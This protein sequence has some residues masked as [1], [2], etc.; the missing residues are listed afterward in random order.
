MT[1]SAWIT[2]LWLRPHLVHE[3]STFLPHIEFHMTSSWASRRF[4][5]YHRVATLGDGWY[6]AIDCWQNEPCGDLWS[7]RWPKMM[8]SIHHWL[9]RGV[10]RCQVSTKLYLHAGLWLPQATSMH[11]ISVTLVLIRLTGE[12]ELIRSDFGWETGFTLDWL[13]VNCTL[14]ISLILIQAHSVCIMCSPVGCLQENKH[15]LV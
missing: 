11:A 4:P 7:G 12:L 10:S 9:C 8:Y 14:V 5:G 3:R 1:S 13:A 15:C 2:L 6:L